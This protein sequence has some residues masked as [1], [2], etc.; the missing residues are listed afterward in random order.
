M[1]S[2]VDGKAPD[3]R[4][5]GVHDRPK[6]FPAQDLEGAPAEP[7]VPFAQVLRFRRYGPEPLY[8]QLARSVEEAVA[9]GEIPHGTRLLPESEMAHELRLAVS[10]VRHAWSYLE[11]KGMLVRTQKAGT[12]IR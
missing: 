11:D 10:T 1:D 7:T 6:R 2:L 4:S 12:F 9:S 5:S 3:P 8:Y